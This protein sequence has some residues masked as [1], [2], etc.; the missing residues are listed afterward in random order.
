MIDVKLTAGGKFCSR[1]TRS[2]C[3]LLAWLTITGCGERPANRARPTITV[4]NGVET[5]LAAGLDDAR[6]EYLVP[7]D[8]PA[9]LL[10]VAISDTLDA[11]GSTN[12]SDLGVELGGNKIAI[13]D[14]YRVVITD[15]A[16]RIIAAAGRKGEGPG[17]FLPIDMICRTRGDTIVVTDARLRTT[18]LDSDVHIVRQFTKTEDIT[19][20]R[21]CLDDG[22]ILTTRIKNAKGGF[23]L[24]RMNSLGEQVASLGE[25]QFDF[26][27]GGLEVIIGFTVDTD[28]KSVFTG[29]P[30]FPEIQQYSAGGVLERIVR[31]DAT[32]KVRSTAPEYKPMVIQRRGGQPVPRIPASVN[33]WPYFESLRVAENGD[34]WLKHYPIVSGAP[35]RWT[36]IGRNGRS[37]GSLQVDSLASASGAIEVRDFTATDVLLR[38]E[39]ESGAVYYKSVPLA[40]LRSR[41]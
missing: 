8:S 1:A 35:E 23:Q 37:L 11:V 19:G 7:G 12:I 18:V 27:M 36:G 9:D 3:A 26:N 25:F 21:R 13:A 15:S 24:N 5:V 39:M 4:K 38:Y 16:H 30:W 28:G 31:W 10:A 34:I 40:K 22:T 29:N 14:G 6:Q 41:K 2:V 20:S 33:F 17:E 32:P